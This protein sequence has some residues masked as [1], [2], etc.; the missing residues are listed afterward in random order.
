MVSGARSYFISLH[1]P[2]PLSSICAADQSTLLDEVSDSYA[3]IPA[4]PDVPSGRFS[5]AEI[6]ALSTKM[7]NSAPGPDGIPYPF[8]KSLAR[9]TDPIPGAPPNPLCLPFDVVFH[10][11]P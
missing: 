11:L 8:W 6:R 3:S 9:P 2:E 1:T 7:P 5:L 4:P 10:R